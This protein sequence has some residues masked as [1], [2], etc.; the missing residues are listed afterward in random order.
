MEHLPQWRHMA[1]GIPVPVQRQTQA[2]NPPPVPVPRP[3]PVK[4]L[5]D[6]MELVGARVQ[7]DLEVTRVQTLA[8][9]QSLTRLVM[10]ALVVVFTLVGVSGALALISWLGRSPA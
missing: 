7:A 1:A 2:P 5:I 9:L 8:E 10:L 4:Y 6:Q 3:T